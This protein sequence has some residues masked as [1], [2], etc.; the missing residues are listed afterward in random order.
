MTD[1]KPPEQPAVRTTIVGGRPPGSGQPCREAPRGIEIL[2]KKAA[3]DRAFEVI[4]LKERVAAAAAI[5]LTLA[6]SEVTL[7]RSVSEAQLAAMVRQTNVRPDLQ[8]IFKGAV[9][10][11]MLAALTAVAPAHAEEP[12][13]RLDP[14][15]EKTA[16]KEAGPQ[17]VET[18]LKPRMVC[19]ISSP[20]TQAVAIFGLVVEDPFKP[21]EEMVEFP[22]ESTPELDKLTT[23]QVQMGVKEL[24]VTL[25][26]E[27]FEVREQAT[28]R[29]MQLGA[30][31]LPLL[32][33]LRPDDPEVTSRLNRI[34]RALE[35]ARQAEGHL[36]LR[37][38]KWEWKT[39]KDN[40][41]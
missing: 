16:P 13:P 41:K 21:G 11:V 29:L 28:L 22:P 31:V 24:T 34:R 6:P 4:L 20:R 25:G 26:D 5:G 14:A 36:Q 12:S 23:E 40:E 19:K 15:T 32:A 27:E 2:L 8:P 3:V 30:R 10:T 17:S 7:L 18:K 33:E 1:S 37:D 35:A 38:G 9:A 39:V